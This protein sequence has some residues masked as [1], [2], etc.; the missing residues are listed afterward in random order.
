MWQHREDDAKAAIQALIDADWG[1]S[2]RTGFPYQ[3]GG[4]FDEDIFKEMLKQI[5][6]ESE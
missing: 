2:E 5:L 4:E 3:V 6:E 1:Y